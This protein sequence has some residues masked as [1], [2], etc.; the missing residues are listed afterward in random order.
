MNEEP[1]GHA[2]QENTVDSLRDW[3][4]WLIGLEFGAGAG[5]I[6][7]FLQSPT[8]PAVTP[9]LVIAI[10]AFGLALACA[11]LLMGEL[12]VITERLPL[13]DGQG[14]LASVFEQSG[15]LGPSIGWLVSRQLILLALASVFLLGWVVMRAVTG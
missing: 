6:A 8:S 15:R 10:A 3:C 12:A 14:R 5:C 1:S 11:V 7:I 4:K 2:A 9:F 13:R